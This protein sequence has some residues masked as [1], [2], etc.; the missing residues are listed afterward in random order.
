MKPTG[1]LYLLPT[2]LGARETPW[3][4]PEDAAKIRP[5]KYFIVEAEKTARRHLKLLDME[6]P[7]REL[8]FAQ[9]NEHSGKAALPELLQ[10][11]LAGENAA[12]MSEAGCPAVA[13]PGADVVALA[14][15]SGIRVVPLAG[16]SSILLA[17]M[18]SGAN[19]QKFA[20]KGYLPVSSEARRACLK[21]LVQKIRS[22]KESQIF[23]ET[24]YRNHALLEDILAVVP[25]DIS[26][27]AAAD[28]TTP[29][30]KII[31]RPLAQ[32]RGAAL[33]DLKK[34]PCIFI[35]F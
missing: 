6:T 25:P 31:S 16:A 10:P 15:R 26:L 19:G 8:V 20:F 29:G 14:H 17:L 22:E 7:L 12:L 33:P 21:T 34:R 9:W 23:I 32:W 30:E 11:L 13:D 35:L 2:P 5:L 3:L 18:A 24:P 27:C 4:L 28:L 1:T